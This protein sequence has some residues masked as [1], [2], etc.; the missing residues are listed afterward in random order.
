[1]LVVY[2]GPTDAVEVPA[3]NCIAVRGEPVEVP[4]EVGASLIEQGTWDADPKV[5]LALVGKDRTRAKK[6][7]QFELDG[8]QRPEVLEKLAKI[9]DP[10]EKPQANEKPEAQEGGER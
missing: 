8:A 2:S 3:A 9:A 1:V 5:V 10:P 7:L 6:F 4:D